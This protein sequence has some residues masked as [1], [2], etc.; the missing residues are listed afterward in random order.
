VSELESSKDT[1]FIDELEIKIKEKSPASG[2]AAAVDAKPV[3]DFT[4]NMILSIVVFR[5]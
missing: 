3:S 5:G 4:V 1:Y 2:S